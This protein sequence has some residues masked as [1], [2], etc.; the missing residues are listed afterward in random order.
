ML[1][2]NVKRGLEMRVKK[3]VITL[4]LVPESLTED[5]KKIVSELTSWFQEETILIPWMKGVKEIAV[6]DC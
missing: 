1:S 6:K 2:Q 4:E 5:D 3:A